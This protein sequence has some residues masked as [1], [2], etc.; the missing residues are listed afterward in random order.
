[1][2]KLI[3]NVISIFLIIFGIA[4]IIFSFIFIPKLSPVNLN[5][6]TIDS[7]NV[8]ISEGFDSI[9]SAMNNASTTAI[10]ISGSIE[11]AKDSLETAAQVTEET[12]KAFNEMSKLVD[13]EIL[14]L[15]P[16]ESVYMYFQDGSESLEQLSKDLTNTGK[17]LKTNTSDIK[18]LGDNLAD[19]SGKIKNLSVS[20]NNAADSISFSQSDKI[21]D[22]FKAYIC[23]LHAMFILAGT[24]LILLN[25]KK[26]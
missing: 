24:S 25:I 5:N 19:I 17:S 13:F 4:G 15:K 26:E 20:Y 14:G 12:S 9:T 3:I 10:G 8:S 18:E 1:M 6:E 22:Y 16:F 7:L 23:I 2:H 11:T 21:I